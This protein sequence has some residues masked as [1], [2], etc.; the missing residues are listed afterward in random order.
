MIAKPKI[1]EKGEVDMCVAIIG[2]SEDYE[3]KFYM[4]KLYHSLEGSE[5]QIQNGDVTDANLHL[6][7]LREKY[8]V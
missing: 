1:N 4:E 6:K 2:I 8:N 7:M 5:Q 3:K